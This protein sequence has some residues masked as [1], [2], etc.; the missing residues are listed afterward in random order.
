MSYNAQ[1]LWDSLKSAR[2]NNPRTRIWFESSATNERVFLRTRK[3]IE[4]WLEQPVISRTHAIKL[5][6]ADRY[7]PDGHITVA[8]W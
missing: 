8:Y 6:V 7:H 4:N 2:R 5:K 1:R 3:A